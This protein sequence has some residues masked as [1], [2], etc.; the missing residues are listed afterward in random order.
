MQNVRCAENTILGTVVMLS[1]KKSD[2][3][4]NVKVEFGEGEGKDLVQ[5]FRNIYKNLFILVK[6]FCICMNIPTK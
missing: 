3:V 2:R 5:I 1:C 4:I 6:I